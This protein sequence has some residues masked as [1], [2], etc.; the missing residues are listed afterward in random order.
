MLD[1]ISS[2]SVPIVIYGFYYYYNG[3]IV[4][5]T[6]VYLYFEVGAIKPTRGISGKLGCNDWGYLKK[7]LKWI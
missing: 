5:L 4:C 6:V 7:L 2:P 3:V 1:F